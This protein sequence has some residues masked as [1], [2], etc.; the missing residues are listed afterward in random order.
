M[1]NTCRIV[2]WHKFDASNAKVCVC[3]LGCCCCCCAIMWQCFAHSQLHIFNPNQISIIVQLPFCF[4]HGCFSYGWV[5]Q[6][7]SFY[8]MVTFFSVS[9]F[10]CFSPLFPFP[11]D[12]LANRACN[13]RRGQTR[14]NDRIS[15]S[16]LHIQ[17]KPKI[18]A[19]Q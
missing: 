3:T 6:T 14:L 16:T 1:P 17:Q 2:H 13:F 9:F 11:L 7:S 12:S 4:S 15:L 8:A 19:N 10:C 5:K 18:K